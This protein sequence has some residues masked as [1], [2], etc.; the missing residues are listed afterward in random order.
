MFPIAHCWLLESIIPAP[1]PAHRLGAAWPDML[2]ESPITHTDSHKRGREL[3]DFARARVVA[4]AP[5]AGEFAAFVAGVLTHGSEPHGF[6]WYSDEAYDNPDPKGR[7]YAFQR[8][9]PLAAATAAACHLPAEMGLWKAHN[10]IEM[11]CDHRL[12]AADRALAERFLAALGDGALVERIAT[13]LAEFYRKPAAQLAT[14]IGNFAT[15]WAPPESPLVQA[16]IYAHQVAVKHHVSDVDVPAL[17][18]L[19]ERAD[20]LVAPDAAAFA[21]RCV[22]SVGD[23]LRELAVDATLWV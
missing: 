17:A 7:G 4:G 16:R 5:E 21:A 12:Y 19:I 22:A 1:L 23:L 3:L 20:A 2:L 11:A 13:H 9:A 6:D 8:A 14:S 18:A 15:W 10:I